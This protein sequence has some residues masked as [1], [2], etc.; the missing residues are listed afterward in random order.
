LK[1][2]NKM[3]WRDYFTEN[4]PSFFKI[5]LFLVAYSFFFEIWVES[6]KSGDSWTILVLSFLMLSWGGSKVHQMLP[7]TRSRLTI[8]CVYYVTSLL[9]AAIAYEPTLNV[10][11][12][13]LGKLAISIGMIGFSGFLTLCISLCTYDEVIRFPHSNGPFDQKTLD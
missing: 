10:G 8:H 3:T 4:L 5:F 11:G 2:E 13:E 6:K 9:Y 7:K 1:E 12:T